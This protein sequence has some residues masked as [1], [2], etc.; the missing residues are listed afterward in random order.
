MWTDGTRD[1]LDAFAARLGLL[2][3][4]AH[5]SHG[6]SG[7]FYH[8]DLRPSKREQAL[9]KGAAFMPL[10]EWIAPRMPKQERAESDV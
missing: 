4:W 9:K 5:F 7:D 2:K 10:K 8:Y 3:R 1:E 6:V